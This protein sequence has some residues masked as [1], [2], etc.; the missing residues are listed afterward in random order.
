VKVDFPNW[1]GSLEDA[2]HHVWR[3]WW[4]EQLF[5]DWSRRK[6]TGRF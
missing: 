6:A 5:Y 1:F 4:A 3:C 2:E